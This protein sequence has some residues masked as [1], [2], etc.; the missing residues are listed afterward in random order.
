MLHVIQTGF[1]FYLKIKVIKFSAFTHH[2]QL[3]SVMTILRPL[4]ILFQIA[5]VKRTSG[6]LHIL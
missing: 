5:K 4:Y 6:R 1:L 2:Q 3:M